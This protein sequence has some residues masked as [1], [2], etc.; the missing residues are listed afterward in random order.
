MFPV[1]VHV[2][3]IPT[4]N[5]RDF[6]GNQ[7]PI[8]EIKIGNKHA[9]NAPISITTKKKYACDV[10]LKNP[11]NPNRTNSTESTPYAIVKTNF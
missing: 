6:L 11:A 5:P 1:F 7:L 9:L 8:I 2:A 10:I 4:K 3:H